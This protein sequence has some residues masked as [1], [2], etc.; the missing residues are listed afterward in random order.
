[1]FEIKAPLR[2]QRTYLLGKNIF[3]AGSIE[4]GKAENWQERIA[5]ELKDCQVNIF[6]PRRDDWDSSWTQSI[7]DKNFN[8]QVTWEMDHL[9]DY[10]DIVVFYFDPKTQAPITLLELGLI[11]GNSEY[12]N[13]QICVC[14]PD[15]FWRKGN[16]EMV[17]DRF[18]LQLVNDIDTM[19][20]WLK[21]R[22][23]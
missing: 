6:N 20:S 2:Y 9:L 7:N 16:V 1:M 8:E 10:C 11:A 15:G 14:C 3:L 4:M 22:V 17:C 18:N 21:D 5:R 23:I 13:K 19:I 12:R